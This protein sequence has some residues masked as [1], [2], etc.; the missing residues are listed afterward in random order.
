MIGAKLSFFKIDIL[1]YFYAE[2]RILS[3]LVLFFILLFMAVL[4]QDSSYLK[5][6]FFFLFF[7]TFLIPA[8]PAKAQPEKAKP[9]RILFLLDASGS[10]A[11]TWNKG[12]S[13]FQ[14][15][16]R[17]V[18]AIMDSIQN[19]NPDVS[20]G[21]RAFGEQ[22]PAKDSNCTDTKLEVN[23]GCQNQSQMKARLGWLQPRGFSPIALSLKKAAEEDFTE[24]DHYAYSIIL[25]TDGG[26][27]CGGDICA[28]VQ[29]LLAKKISFTPYILTLIDYKPIQD[30]YN[31]L[32]KVLTIAKEKDIAPAV[33]KIIGDNRKIF[34]VNSVGIKIAPVSKTEYPL[35]PVVP[36]KNVQKT[37]L[38][39]P[40]KEAE[41]PMEIATTPKEQ[42]KPPTQS[43]VPETPAIDRIVQK[44][45]VRKANLLFALPAPK[46]IK[47]AAKNRILTLPEKNKPL[48]TITQQTVVEPAAKTVVHP[49]KPKPEIKKEIKK[50]D[51][52]TTSENAEKTTLLVYFTDG[53][54]KF[55]HTE[56]LMK[57]INDK[58]GKEV[59]EVYRNMAGSDPAPIEMIAGT[60][61]IIIPG[62][63]SKAEHISILPNKT[64]KV[65]IKAG[66]ASLAF[67]YS[68]KPDSPI[69]EYIAYVSDRFG[70]RKV[71]TQPCD[72]AF[73]YDPANYHVEINTLPKLVYNIDLSFN[74]LRMV[75]IPTPGTF[76]VLN[77]NPMGKIQLWHQ[78]GNEYVPFL[79]MNITGHPSIQKV[80]LLPGQY[81][82]R[83]F[84]TPH[85]PYDVS[86]IIPF[87]I[88]SEQT[89]S[90]TLA[91]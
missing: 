74:E 49:S 3:V 9:A 71:T 24:D 13:R 7:T 35:R 1:F 73:P 91:N 4:K 50:V 23:F 83:Y 18:I 54:G 85:K 10:M 89:T 36:I 28:T 53:K 33:Q 39:K 8:Q 52:Y 59:K 60:Y 75:V 47:F 61:D 56:P 17:I 55:Y 88:K 46:P 5:K 57:I 72:Q 34:E 78:L 86:I 81:Q 30:A 32:G 40:E 76:Q 42:P 25:I 43:S 12:E 84:N 19:V 48:I 16:S 21:L 80:N 38:I 41:P 67:Y 66:S 22:Y 82:I 62:S 77:T 44:K 29:E 63:D 70:Q 45:A 58:T 51:F 26:E 68:T 11:N 15:A 37:P 31:C 64:N 87:Q 6:I 2:Y 69:K 20:F 79:D 65:Y 14:A 90:I 27:S